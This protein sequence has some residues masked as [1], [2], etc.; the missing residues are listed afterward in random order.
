MSALRQ[1]LYGLALLAA[2]GLFAFAQQQRLARA[3][4][5]AHLAIQGQQ[6]AEQRGER[7]QL[8]IATLESHLQRERRAQ[9]DL[10]QLQA[11]LQQGLADRERTIENL[12]RE[13]R[14]L[15]HW[16]DQPLPPPA[17]RLRQRPALTGAA[18][19]HQWL[20]GSTALHPSSNNP[21]P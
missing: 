4:S 19:Y 18:A 15:Q 11:R 9:T 1:V 21:N 8:T 10:R 7:Q 3:E 16:A 14:D 12:K 20:S 5:E 2:L 6:Q 13:N 17:H